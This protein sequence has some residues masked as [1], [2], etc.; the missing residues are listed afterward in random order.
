MLKLCTCVYSICYVFGESSIVWHARS[1]VLA[2]RHPSCYSWPRTVYLIRPYGTPLAQCEH[3]VA[4]IP[5]AFCSNFLNSN[6][7]VVAISLK[8][9]VI[10]P[11]IYPG[12]AVN[13][14]R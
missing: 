13:V 12:G 7:N 3:R 9:E 8:C 2:I 10:G 14:L 5:H 6:F 4:H 11:V 1:C